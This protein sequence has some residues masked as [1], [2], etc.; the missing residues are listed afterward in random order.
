[1][2]MMNSWFVELMTEAVWASS[3]KMMS[4]EWVEAGTDAL[5][6]CVPKLRF[7]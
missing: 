7:C 3:K 6:E 5:S 1:M 2:R 4:V